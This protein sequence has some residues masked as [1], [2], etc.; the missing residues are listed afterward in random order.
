MPS[1][2]NPYI[3]FDGSAREAMEFYR[4]VFGGELTLSTFGE[5][6][7]P[8]A[9]GADKIMHAQLEAHGMVLMAADTPPGMEF[10]RGT[11]VAISR[12]GDDPDTLRGYWKQLSEGGTVSVALE[13]Q[14]WGDEFGMCTDSFGVSWMVNI[15]GEQ[16]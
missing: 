6:G 16:A 9:P 14:M 4:T 7:Q 2:L 11:D 3:Q 13:K 8:D 15:A 10:T 5:Y 12:S 1:R